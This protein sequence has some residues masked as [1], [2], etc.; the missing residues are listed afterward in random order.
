MLS[1]NSHTSGRGSGADVDR[2]ERPVTTPSRAETCCRKI[3]I[4]VLKVI[5]QSSV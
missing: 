4:S 5:T 1:P 2:E 3:S